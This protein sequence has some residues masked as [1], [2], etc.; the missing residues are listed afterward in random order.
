M[1]T[2]IL[3]FVNEY[4]NRNA[5]RL[6][7]PGHKGVNIL[8]VERLDVTEIDGADSLYHANGIIEKSELNASALFSSH[9]F[10]STEG[11]SLSIRAMLYLAVK[12]AKSKGKQPL[13]LAPR[14][15]HKT[16]ISA[17]SLLDFEIQWIYS[18]STDYLSCKI[19]A[20]ALNET[21]KNS[22]QKPVAVYITSPDYLGNLLDV[23]GIAEVC[24][25]HGVLLLVDNAH[26][27]YAKFLPQSMHPIDLGADVCCDSAH[28]TLP[29]L[30]GGAYLHI[31]Y[32]APAEFKQNARDALALFGSTSPSYLIL[33][34]LDYT[35]KYIS[36]DY[37]NKLS[38]TVKK[39]EVLKSRL[40]SNGYS[41]IDSEPL[42]I[43]LRT[44]EYGYTGYEIN[45]F[46]QKNDI[47]CEFYDPDYLVLMLSCENLDGDIDKLA[48]VLLS[49]PKK[50]PI[51][52]A[53]PKP[54]ILKRKTSIRN[55]MLC[56]SET[57]NVNDSL[58]RVLASPSVSCPPAVP[59]VMCGEEIDKDAVKSFQYYGIKNINVVKK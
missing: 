11:S 52:V 23:K 26:G 14:N 3:D 48:N 28:K 18:H 24:K 27:A 40:I 1:D 42:K 55:A 45:D 9:T 43:T 39:I 21:L 4:A 59:I 29:T 33:Q 12:Y 32:N 46:L 58:G 41:L 57:I 31:S 49:L 34:S 50:E 51:L 30:T 22:T 7:V 36:L 56:P 8:G 6:H 35:N 16:F 2:P 19:D 15:V 13:I 54:T 5:V 44:K 17:A 47:V 20:I 10:Y 37:K 25:A 38:K 53:P